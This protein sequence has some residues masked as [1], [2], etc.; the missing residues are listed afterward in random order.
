MEGKRG[1]L[2]SLTDR[3]K[4]AKL[5]NKAVALG[6]RQ[7]KACEVI[8]LSI[9]TLQRWRIDGAI[10]EDKRPTAIRPEP[11]NKLSAQERQAVIDVCNVQ[12]FASLPPSQIAVSYTHLTLP[13][14]PYV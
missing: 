13:T 12:E 4:H 14:T 10:G 1:Q 9:R 6:A 3:Q 7:A 2:I 11:L 5:I 8:G